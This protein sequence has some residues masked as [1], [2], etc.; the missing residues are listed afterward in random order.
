[1]NRSTYVDQ[2]NQRIERD[3]LLCQSLDTYRAAMVQ[4]RMRGL[5]EALRVYQE[6][7]TTLREARRGQTAKT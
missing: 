6:H 5:Q 2:L 7:N 3:A 4:G 1:M